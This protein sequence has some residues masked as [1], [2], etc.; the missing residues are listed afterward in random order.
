MKKTQPISIWFIIAA[1]TFVVWMFFY[2]TTPQDLKKINETKTYEE[3]LEY[4]NINSKKKKRTATTT[5]TV[6]SQYNKPITQTTTNKV[7]PNI[8]AKSNYDKLLDNLKTYPEKSVLSVQ[9]IV[10]EILVFRGYPKGIIKVIAEDLSSPIEKTKGSYIGA[11]FNFQTGN[12]HINTNLLYKENIETI[13]AIIAHELDHFDK[14]AQICKSQGVIKFRQMFKDSGVE[15]LNSNFWATN[16]IYANLNNFNSE[17]YSNA[18]LRYINQTNIDRLSPYADFY[19]L[20][21]HVR[22]PLE[23][24]AYEISDYILNYY[25]KNTTIGPTT[26]IVKFFNDADWAIYNQVSKYNELKNER[27]AFFDYFFAQAI[28]EVNPPFAKLLTHCDNKLNGNMANFWTIYKVEYNNFY[29]KNKTLDATTYSKI[30]H[31]LKLT[32]DK[33]NNIMTHDTIC[34]ALKLK[35]GTLRNNITYERATSDLENAIVAY[36]EYTKNNNLNKQKEILDYTLTLICI[37]NN[38]YTTSPDITSLSSIE[39]PEDMTRLFAIT[40]KRGLAAFIYNNSEFQRLLSEEQKRK[41]NKSNSELYLNLISEHKL[42][43]MYK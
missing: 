16:C 6:T 30:L 5:K 23:I 11:F 12:M 1:I 42:K 10:D 9:R 41:P 4:T 17:Y 28:T 7:S 31:L 25:G 35:I 3:M 13:I 40:K 43:I 22:N 20:S 18:L 33:A 2:L 32:K 24:S 21:E 29:N 8:E 15:T 26:L 37:K 36:L 27:I 39:I 38:L 14:I 34:N 19:I